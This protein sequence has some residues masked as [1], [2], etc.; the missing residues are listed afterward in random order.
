MIR[1]Q[2][3]NGKVTSARLGGNTGTGFRRAYVRYTDQYGA[4][5][6]VSGRVTNRH[7]FTNDRVLPFEVKTGGV[8]GYLVLTGKEYAR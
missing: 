1:V 8:N 2:L 7:G 5:Y 6:S 3:P 4:R